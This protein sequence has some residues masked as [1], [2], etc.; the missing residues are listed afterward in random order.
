MRLKLTLTPK[1]EGKYGLINK[2]HIQGFIYNVLGDILDHDSNKFKFYNFSNI[3]PITDFKID[4]EKHLIISSPDATLINLLEERLN[5]NPIIKLNN[6]DFIVQKVRK[7]NIYKNHWII[8]DVC[9]KID[10][11]TYWRKEHGILTFL[12]RVTENAKKKYK[13]FCNEEED[14]EIISLKFIKTYTVHLTKKDKSFYIFASK[15][16]FKVKNSKIAKFIFDCGV[17]EKNSLG[18]GFVN[19]LS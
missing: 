8:N 3:F 4:E 7:F 14:F 5:E 11:N 19:P 2:H 17:G 6:F 13:E 12:K 18:F 9:V 15:W 1:F 10:R 16:E